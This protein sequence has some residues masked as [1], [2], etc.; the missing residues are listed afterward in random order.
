MTQ[1]DLEMKQENSLNKQSQYF[2]WAAAAILV[3][4]LLLLTYG[5]RGKF[6]PVE[7][8][9]LQQ[10]FISI[11]TLRHPVIE[12]VIDWDKSLELNQEASIVTRKDTTRIELSVRYR[13]YTM[14]QFGNFH[15][16]G[17]EY[18]KPYDR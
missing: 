9:D 12:E 2:F 1:N 11:D 16:T 14:D 7:T 18:I 8:G 3:A 13:F 4:T 6:S 10:T 15:E 5:Y 17:L